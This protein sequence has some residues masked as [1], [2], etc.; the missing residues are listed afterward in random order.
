MADHRT[1]TREQV[2]RWRENW[3]ESDRNLISQHLDRLSAGAFY[4]PQSQAYVGCK[5][6]SD[7]NVVMYVNP[8]YLEFRKDTS[9]PG[10]DE[11]V[12]WIELST[13]V[14]RGDATLLLESE[15]VCPKCSMM[16]P[17]S[18]VCDCDE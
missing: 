15:Q 4:E 10:L 8:G 9:P 18:G 11:G 14:A 12:N 6:A 13:F 17:L 7:P 2:L 5:Q 3:S 16:L 1:L